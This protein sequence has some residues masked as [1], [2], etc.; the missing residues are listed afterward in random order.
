MKEAILKLWHECRNPLYIA[1]KLGI[2]DEVTGEP[3]VER[4]EQVI[5]GEA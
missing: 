1:Q 5:E 2:I 3:D 4:V